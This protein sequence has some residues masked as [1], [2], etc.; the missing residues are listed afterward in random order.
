MSSTPRKKRNNQQNSSSAHAHPTLHG[1]QRTRSQHLAVQQADLATQQITSD[2]ESDT[3]GY[4]AAQTLPNP[5]LA[6]R[7]VDNINL[8]VLKRYI[9]S[10]TK[11]HSIASNA[12]FYTYENSPDGGAFEKANTE[13]PLFACGLDETNLEYC[14]FILNRKTTDN[15][16]MDLAKVINFEQQGEMLYAQSRGHDGE[17]KIWGLFIHDSSDNPRATHVNSIMNL[18]KLATLPKPPRQTALSPQGGQGP[19]GASGFGGRQ[20]GINELFKR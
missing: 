9:P 4:T 1:H 10:I 11:I 16:I 13:G 18:W 7:S 3:A 14:I 20:I 15:L 12:V 5:A 17:L 6:Q 8:T 19:H 2:Y